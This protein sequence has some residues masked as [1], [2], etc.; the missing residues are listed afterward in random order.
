MPCDYASRHAMPIPDNLTKQQRKDWGNKDKEADAE[1]WIH[2]IFESTFTTISRDEM[3][4]ATEED[5]V[6]SDI[7]GNI[8]KG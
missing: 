2:S 6:L 5:E 4:E 8:K 1:I 3:K 7:M